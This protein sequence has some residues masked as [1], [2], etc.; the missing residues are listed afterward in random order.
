MS[1]V[2][3]RECYSLDSESEFGYYPGDFNLTETTRPGMQGS[4]PL[5]HDE[6]AIET[7]GTEVIETTGDLPG[8]ESELTADMLTEFH[9]IAD[10]LGIDS[11]P[12]E[13]EGDE[14]ESTVQDEGEGADGVLN[15]TIGNHNCVSEGVPTEDFNVGSVDPPYIGRR[16]QRERKPTERFTYGTLGEPTRE[17]VLIPQSC[18]DH[19]VTA[20][21]VQFPD[22]FNRLH[23]WWCTP[24]TLC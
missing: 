8:V 21:T 18:S 1:D 13:S 11:Y 4:V 20:K 16:S 5:E 17:T 9:P 23:A 6:S 10:L 14:C 7:A 12:A 2:P 19:L 22:N 3:Q 15:E 24:Q